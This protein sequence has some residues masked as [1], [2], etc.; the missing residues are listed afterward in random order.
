M[1]TKFSQEMEIHQ[2][3]SVKIRS[4]NL[5]NILLINKLYS[6]FSVSNW[7]QFLAKTITSNISFCLYNI[8]QPRYLYEK[9]AY[10]SY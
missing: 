10:L 2:V 8:C 7:Y 1:Y 9:P 5:I 4:D 3:V 6:T